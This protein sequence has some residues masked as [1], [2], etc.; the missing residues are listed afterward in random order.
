MGT[1]PPAHLAGAPGL[2]QRPRLRPG[3]KPRPKRLAGTAGELRPS[4]EPCGDAGE[5]ALAQL[6]HP[7]EPVAA[8]ALLTERNRTQITLTPRTTSDGAALRK[9]I[10]VSPVYNVYCPHLLKLPGLQQ[11]T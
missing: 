3:S 10:Q 7:A 6:A 11:Q 2:E 4:A 8:L 9:A 5:P 1:V